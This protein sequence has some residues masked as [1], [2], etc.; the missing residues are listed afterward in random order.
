MVRNAVIAVLL[1]LLFACVSDGLPENLASAASILAYVALGFAIVSG[2]LS[3]FEEAEEP[4][5]GEMRHSEDL[6]RP[7][8]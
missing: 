7:E 3:L 2:L 6:F 8:Y 5:G 4:A 1:T